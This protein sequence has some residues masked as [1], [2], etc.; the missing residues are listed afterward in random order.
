MALG[1]DWMSDEQFETLYAFSMDYNAYRRRNVLES[2][3]GRKKI[4]AW[5]KSA[6]QDI[7]EEDRAWQM[8]KML[9]SLP[10]VRWAVGA[11]VESPPPEMRAYCDYPRGDVV[12]INIVHSAVSL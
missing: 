12:H 8:G 1:L 11:G 2:V 5:A 3:G 6:L 4:P 10:R 9:R 7:A